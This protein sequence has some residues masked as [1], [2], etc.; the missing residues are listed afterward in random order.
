MTSL[1]RL[2]RDMLLR[3]RVTPGGRAML[4]AAAVALEPLDYYARRRAAARYNQQFPSR[5]MTA[6]DGHAMLPGLPSA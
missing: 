4:N 1:N 3:G 5:R 6:V 2:K